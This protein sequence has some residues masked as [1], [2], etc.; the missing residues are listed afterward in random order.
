M[1]PQ[2]DDLL[3]D[4]GDEVTEEPLPGLTYRLSE[5]SHTVE[6][7]IDEAEALKQ[8]IYCIL[9]TERFAHEIYSEDYGTELVDTVGEPMPFVFVD[10]EDYI[11]EALE[12]DD[13]VVS[14]DG[15]RFEAGRNSVHVTFEVESVFGSIAVDEEVKL[16]G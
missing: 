14:V 8:T 1:I 12:Q 6:G 10:I 9:R 2:Q 3:F 16:N 13:R 7:L 11:R 15:F 5:E 4:D